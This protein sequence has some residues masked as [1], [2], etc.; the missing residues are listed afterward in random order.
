MP[1]GGS[2]RALD[3]QVVALPY[4]RC[5]YSLHYPIYLNWCD[6]G[7]L[8]KGMRHRIKGPLC[9]QLIQLLVDEWIERKEELLSFQ[10]DWQHCSLQVER[11]QRSSIPTQGAVEHIWKLGVWP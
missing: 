8:P 11:D 10:T 9:N 5:T 4:L 2:L 1:G 6:D 3:K 7:G